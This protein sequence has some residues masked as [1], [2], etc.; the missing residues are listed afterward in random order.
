MPSSTS[1]PVTVVIGAGPGLGMSVA[2]RFGRAGHRVALVS[3]TAARHAGYLS[4]LADAGVTASAH[5]ADVRVADQLHAALDAIRERHGRIDVVY[6]GPAAMDPSSSPVPIT[7]VGRASVEDAMSWVYPAV[8]VVTSVLPE[9]VARGDGGL[10]FGGGLSA[11]L[12]MPA[13]GNLAV[14]SAA[15]RNYALTLNAGLAEHGVYAGMLTIG[16]LI[17]RGDIHTHIAADPG[18]FGDLSNATLNPD[19]LAEAAW[20]MYERRDRAEETFNVLG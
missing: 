9:M 10:L 1:A 16:G 13:L 4:S 8:D 12:P 19:D 20:G 18:T 6:Y 5:A 17:E 15:L 2:H 14:S 11:V 3:R 7:E